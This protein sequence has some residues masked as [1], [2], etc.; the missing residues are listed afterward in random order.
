MKV[1]G[2]LILSGKT[3]TGIKVPEEVV[4]ALGK[5]RKPP[6]RVT[7]NGH[8]WRGSVAFMGGE[9]WLSV[10]AENRE[11]AGV[12]AGELLEIDLEPDTAPREVEVPADLAEALEGEPEAKRYFEGLS[13]SNKRR[14]IL[15]IEGAKAAETRQR[16]ID[17]S[18]DMFKEG[19]N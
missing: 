3:S 1:S 4:N 13:Y 11:A 15:A 12:K 5:S 19:R 6:V 10:S 9:F 16:R 17:K 8:T 14:H 18:V 2:P 7:L